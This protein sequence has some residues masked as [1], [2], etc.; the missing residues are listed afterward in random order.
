[1]QN[2]TK[3]VRLVS[4]TSGAIEHLVIH[5]SDHDNKQIVTDINKNLQ[6]ISDW[7]L[8]ND[9]SEFYIGATNLSE[10]FTK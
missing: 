7:V 6:Q 8:D 3:V 9:D 4:W 1:M 10:D 2:D 5:P